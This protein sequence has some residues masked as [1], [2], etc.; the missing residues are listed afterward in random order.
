M[1]PERAIVSRCAAMS[2]ADRDKGQLIPGAVRGSSARQVLSRAGQHPRSTDWVTLR[3]TPNPESPSPSYRIV[4]AG[5][6]WPEV[7]P[8]YAETAPRDHGNA[9]VAPPGGGGRANRPARGSY[10]LT[11][12]VPTFCL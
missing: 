10:L 12:Q 8:A 4:Q 11:W 9:E 2:G 1:H 7:R 5:R 3:S 6:G